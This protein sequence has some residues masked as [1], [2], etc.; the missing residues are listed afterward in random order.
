MSIK[1]LK[2]DKTLI[3]YI[4]LCFVFGYYWRIWQ[5]EL[6]DLKVD[7]PR[8]RFLIRFL[9]G[10]GFYILGLAYLKINRINLAPK[11]LTIIYLCI[12][13]TLLFIGGFRL[14][15]F[16]HSTIVSLYASLLG[17]TVSPLALLLALILSSLDLTKSKHIDPNTN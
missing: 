7:N 8:Y 12:E 13:L 11:Y 16:D 9:F 17:L 2:F 5:I 15:V 1:A 10:L 3:V 4:I 14:F 6:N